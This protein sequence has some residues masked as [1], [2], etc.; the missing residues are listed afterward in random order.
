MIL[1]LH[2]VFFRYLLQTPTRPSLC[3]TSCWKT[4]PSSWTSWATSRQTDL[5]TSSSAMRRTIWWSRSGTW[6]DPRPPRKLQA[7]EEHCFIGWKITEVVVWASE[8]WMSVTRIKENIFKN[9]TKS[10]RKKVDITSFTVWFSVDVEVIDPPC[11]W[12]KNCYR[13]HSASY[14]VIIKQL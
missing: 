9:L 2:V 13:N 7:E 6:R 12:A 11:V 14:L 1:Y 5:R 4:K 3:W 8:V 10:N